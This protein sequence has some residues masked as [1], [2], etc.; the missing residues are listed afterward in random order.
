[1][2]TN[3][4]MRLRR[5]LSLAAALALLATF[6][7]APVAR[8]ETGNVDVTA[9]ISAFTPSLTLDFCDQ[10]ADFGSGLSASADPVTGTTDTVDPIPLN[11]GLPNGAFYRWT[12]SC[13]G[14]SFIT[15]T[16]N[17]SWSGTVCG[18]LSGGTGTS[19]LTLSDL[20]Y[21][22]ALSLD[23]NTISSLS[24]PF[25]DCGSP[26]PWTSQPQSVTPFTFDYFY[27]LQIDPNDT[28]GSFTA[29]TTW[30]VTA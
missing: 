1:M 19:S 3:G 12:P 29:T 8:A 6:S 20:R 25:Q 22:G 27:Y 26:A 2:T 21:A 5:S 11:T 7:L 9:N 14:V 24:T 30:E 28:A 23:Y 10:S 18:T 4:T 13:D 15:V 17:V 16:S